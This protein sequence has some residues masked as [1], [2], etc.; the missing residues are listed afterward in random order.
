VPVDEAN[1]V[2]AT[3]RTAV[4]VGS[5]LH[6]KKKTRQGKTVRWVDTVR[7]RA[8]VDDDAGH[9]YTFLQVSIECINTSTGTI[10]NR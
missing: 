8:K 1:E 2:G 9:E 5:I 4:S 3:S 10:L 7:K 6:L